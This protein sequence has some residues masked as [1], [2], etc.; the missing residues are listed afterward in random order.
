MAIFVLSFFGDAAP[1]L[2]CA[3]ERPSAMYIR[4]GAGM[5]SLV[6]LVL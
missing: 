3:V 1:V 6:L 2:R 5:C 4:A